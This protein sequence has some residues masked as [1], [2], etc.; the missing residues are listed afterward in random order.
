MKETNKSVDIKHN[1]DDIIDL[2]HHV[3]K[4]HKQMSIMNRAAQFA[5]FAALTGYDDEIKET[6]RLTDKKIE[7]DDNK[8]DIINYQLQLIQ[9]KIKDK[10]C[11]YIKYFIPDTKKSGGKYETLNK[12]VKRIDEYNQEIIFIDKT[13]VLINNIIDIKIKKSK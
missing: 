11:V 1:Y 2:P 12:N 4:K 7:I 6:A 5:P 13:K 10:P 9:S 3:S 8:I